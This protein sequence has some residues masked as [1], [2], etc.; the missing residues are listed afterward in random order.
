ML[1]FVALTIGCDDARRAT[2]TPGTPSAAPVA[3]PPEPRTVAPPSSAPSVGASAAAPPEDKCRAAPWAMYGHDAARTSAAEGCIRGPLSL[4]WQAVYPKTCGFKFQPGRF[5]HVIADDRA[6]YATLDCGHAPALMRITLAGEVT[7]TFG[8]GDYGRGLW[9][10]L[11]GDDAI[12]S[13][14]D[15]VF[16]ID[17]ETGKFRFRELDIWGEPLTVGKSIYVANT[18]QLDSAGP[19]LGAIDDSLRWRWRAAEINPGKGK[20]VARIGGTALDG[21]TIV[22]AAAMGRRGIPALAAFDTASGQQRWLA[23]KTFPVSA[24][25]IASG[26]VFTMEQFVG[27]KGNRLV[28]RSLADGAVAWSE[29]VPW[30]RGPSPVLVEKLVVVHTSEGVRA[31]DQE[32][33]KLA[34]SNPTP[35]K[36]AAEEAATSLAA[37]KGSR[38][39][40]VTSG[41]R[42]VVLE[43]E[44]GTEQWN[45]AVVRG[46]SPTS[47]S[48]KVVGRPVIVGRSLYISSD[49]ALLRFDAK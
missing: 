19:F 43:V 38:T 11:Y 30:A 37:A 31:F 6:L 12:V 27:Q 2:P 15:G 26:R 39:L 33:G 13:A 29:E 42:V 45:D 41:A 23:E 8:R 32:S 48:G 49:G 22:H 14:D 34:W 28:A 35:R 47:F 5:L 24:P 7:W 25:S 17:R 44:G 1:A 4:V 36:A 20:D 46:S 10:A 21:D 9:P 16:I 3:A 18:F 40:V